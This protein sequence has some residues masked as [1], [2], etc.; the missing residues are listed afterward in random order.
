ALRPAPAGFRTLPG[1]LRVRNPVTG[2][3]RTARSSVSLG[4]PAT[5]LAPVLGRFVRP[6]PCREK[7]TRP[8]GRRQIRVHHWFGRTD[9]R[10]LLCGRR[11]RAPWRARVS[12]MDESGLD[13]TVFAE[14]ALLGVLL[15]FWQLVIGAVV[16]VVLVLSVGR[17]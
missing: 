15:P 17:L 4:V 11:R 16:L 3:S 12:G 10:G 9:R 2:V 8:A 13:A 14:E 5:S 6:P 7:V 1:R